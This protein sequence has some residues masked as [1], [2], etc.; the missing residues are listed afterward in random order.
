M[1]LKATKRLTTITREKRVCRLHSP[2]STLH[3]PEVPWSL[4]SDK[5]SLQVLP[6]R[7]LLDKCSYAD[8][9]LGHMAPN[10]RPPLSTQELVSG[11]LCFSLVVCTVF[12]C[13]EVLGMKALERPQLDFST[14]NEL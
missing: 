4:S 10:N 5:P 6:H 11:L 14:V 2:S 8:L 9:K 3:C 7:D 1:V 13:N 12:P